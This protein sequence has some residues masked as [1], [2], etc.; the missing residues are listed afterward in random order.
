ME[1]IS[2]LIAAIQSLFA[3]TAA[4]RGVWSFA[5][6]TIFLTLCP[7]IFGDVGWIA[8][9][10][11]VAYAIFVELCRVNTEHGAPYFNKISWK[12]LI[13]DGVGIVVGVFV[14]LM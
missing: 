7:T 8:L 4:T 14:A 9:A 5:I 2:K 13:A 1:T 11:P 6:T 3:S 12:A 10:I